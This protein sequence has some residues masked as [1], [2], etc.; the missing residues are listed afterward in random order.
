QEKRSADHVSRNSLFVACMHKK[1]RAKD[2]AALAQAVP[3]ACC[4]YLLRLNY[5]QT[6]SCKPGE[7]A[8]APAHSTPPG[9]YTG[10]STLEC[11]PQWTPYL[12]AD[13]RRFH[14]PHTGC[15]F[16]P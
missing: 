15:C 1:R 4:S 9:R 2:H 6:I 8:A 7:A 3:A 14:W 12:C 16:N 5:D 13:H 11:V 10:T